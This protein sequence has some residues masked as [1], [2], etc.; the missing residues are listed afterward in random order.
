MKFGPKKSMA[1]ALEGKRLHDIGLTWGTVCTKLR[2]KRGWI[3]YW[4]R[5]H[6]NKLD[7]TNE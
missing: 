1:I 7:G 2:V 3:K 5:H 6:V 4:M